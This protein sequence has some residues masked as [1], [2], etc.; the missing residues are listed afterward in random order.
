MP[1]NSIT[2]EADQFPESHN[3]PKVTQG[4]IGNLNSPTSI[5]EIEYVVKT[6]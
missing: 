1:I 4:E 6:L 3:V 5:K 2:D